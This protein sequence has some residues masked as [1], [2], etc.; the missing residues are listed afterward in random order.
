MIARIAIVICCVLA[1]LS[2]STVL[3]AQDN[4]SPSKKVMVLPFDGGSAGAFSYLTDPIRSMVT[5]RLAGQEGVEVVDYGLRAADI[6]KLAEGET[7]VEGGAS[8]FSRFEL[9]YIVTGGLYALQT[10][11][12]IQVSV[13]GKDTEGEPVNL[14]VLAINEESVIGQVELL[15]DEISG[16]GFG[17]E[18]SGALEI[19]SQGG[20]RDGLS[21]FT[22][23][24][25]EKM[26]KKGVYTGA[27]VA[28]EGGVSVSSAGVRR[29]RIIPTMLVTMATGDLD[30]DGVQEV[31]SAART[32]LSIVRFNGS[33]FVEVASYKFPKSAKVNAVNV[34]DLDGD[35]KPEI[36]V[37]AN[38]RE[39]ASSAIFSFDGNSLI[40]LQENIRWFIRPVNM[41]GE[42]MVLAGQRD[43]TDH[44]EGFIRPGVSILAVSPADYKV[45][46]EKK[47]PLPAGVNLFDFEYAD[48]EGDNKFELVAVDHREKV[49]VYDSQNSL[50]WVSEKDYGGSRNFFGPAKSDGYSLHAMVADQQNHLIDR[51]IVFIPARIVVKDIDG[52]GKQEV[53]IGQNKRVYG[54]WFAN[55]REYDGGSVVCLGWRQGSLQELWRT[56]KLNGYLADYNFVKK[57]DTVDG[58]EADKAGLYVAQIPDRMRL[59]FLLR[60]ESKLLRY[61]LEI[62]SEPQI[63]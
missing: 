24:H 33:K 9:D 57:G 55:S 60:K 11:L 6:K 10:G 28:E 30:G 45:S 40:P 35:S 48:L 1:C 16:K 3:Q 63:Q 44:E 23:E 8:L 54:K 25:P 53:I 34:A 17:L 62:K 49:L 39:R 27:I 51:K 26:Y 31:V 56:N 7:T 61:D 32:S 43:S 29:S 14:N 21:G 15:V 41:P 13:I 12:K 22:T 5:S 38:N 20:E 47:L 58:G 50:M 42:R 46:E 18:T 36:Y 59:G 4:T 19:A 2:H 52:D 37:S